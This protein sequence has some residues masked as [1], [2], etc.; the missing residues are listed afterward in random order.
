MRVAAREVLRGYALASPAS[1]TRSLPNRGPCLLVPRDVRGRPVRVPVLLLYVRVRDRWEDVWRSLVQLVLGTFMVW[2]ARRQRLCE[3]HF[4][5]GRPDNGRADNG[6]PEN[7]R[8]E[9]RETGGRRDA[10]NECPSHHAR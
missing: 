5:N 2:D 9:G 10:R 3:R 1:H 8:P 6:R 4:E 7:G